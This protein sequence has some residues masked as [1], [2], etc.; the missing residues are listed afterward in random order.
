[1]GR[2]FDEQIV[3]S[4]VGLWLILAVMLGV[5]LVCWGI[6]YLRYVPDE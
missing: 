4:D 2:L 3:E 6:M 5:V 1:V